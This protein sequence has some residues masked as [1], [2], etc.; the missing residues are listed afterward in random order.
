ML[1]YFDIGEERLRLAPCTPQ[2]PLVVKNIPLKDDFYPAIWPSFSFRHF[3][4]S[5]GRLYLIETFK[6]CNTQF[7]VMEMERDYS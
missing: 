3:G 2:I 7:D 6:H 5:G 1:H 4:E